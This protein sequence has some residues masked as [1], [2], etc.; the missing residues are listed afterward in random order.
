MKTVLLAA[1]LAVSTPALAESTIKLLSIIPSS[2]V[3][4]YEVNNTQY[5]VDIK[6]GCHY[7]LPNNEPVINFNYTPRCDGA[8]ESLE[9]LA[10]VL[11]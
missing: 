4:V 10:K 3:V 2:D 7:E 9:D 8:M 6:D 11:I 1:M 5:W